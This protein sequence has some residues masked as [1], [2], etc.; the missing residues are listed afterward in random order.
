[1]TELSQLTD[2]LESLGADEGPLPEAVLSAIEGAW[3]GASADQLP[4]Y[5]GGGAMPVARL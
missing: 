5:P 4:A 3:E 1:M 2:N